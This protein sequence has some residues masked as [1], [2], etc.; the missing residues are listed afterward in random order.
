MSEQPKDHGPAFPQPCTN[1]GHAAN[2][3][4]GIAGGGLSIQ[5][6]F[7]GQALIGILSRGDHDLSTSEYGQYAEDAWMIAGE[8]LRQ[9]ATR[10]GKAQ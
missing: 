3:P 7:A 1:E 6:W 10:Y 4:W 5:D 2:T 9:R 8:M